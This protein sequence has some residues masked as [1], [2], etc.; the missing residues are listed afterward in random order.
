MEQ[1]EAQWS[2]QRRRIWTWGAGLALL[3]TVASSQAEQVSSG[4]GGLRVTAEHSTVVRLSP[5]VRR[6]SAHEAIEPLPQ[7]AVRQF[8]RDHR[9]VDD[10]EML[11]GLAYVVAGDDRRIV[12]GAGDRVY[13]R[14]ELQHGQRYGVYRVGERY[15]D[16]TSDE[17]L[18]LELVSIGQARAER[19]EG[20]VTAL[21]LLSTTQEVRNEDIV[22]PLEERELHGEFMPR[23]PDHAI[24]GVILG[25]PEGVRFIGRLQVVALDRGHRDGLEAGH[26]LEV[27]QQGEQI[28]DP[29][30]GESL[31]LPGSDAGRIMLFQTYEKMSYGLVMRATCAL[32]VGDRV[33]NPLSQLGEVQR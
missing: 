1:K 20:D 8:L 13:A 26:V 11:E 9:V 22:L 5:E 10:P 29:R 16:T 7:D 17:V 3:L 28:V 18:G 2:Y 33:H 24:S 19:S 12:S 6:I 14:G 23:V 15:V 31:S 32:A 4:Q 25:A 30:T 27:E 21:T